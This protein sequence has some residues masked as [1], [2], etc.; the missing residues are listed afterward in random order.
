MYHVQPQKRGNRAVTSAQH[1]PPKHCGSFKEC[2]V[3][4]AA[5]CEGLLAGSVQRNGEFP[6]VFIATAH[7]LTL[8]LMSTEW[9]RGGVGGALG[10]SCNP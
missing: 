8:Y 5:V 2:R 4:A 6:L 10:R 9:T 3:E 7:L 1:T